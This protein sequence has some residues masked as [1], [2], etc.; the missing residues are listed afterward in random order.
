[1]LALLFLA[2]VQP[3]EPPPAFTILASADEVTLVLASNRTTPMRI[4]DPKDVEG[5]SYSLIFIRVQGPDG[6]FV[7]TRDEDGWWTPLYKSAWPVLDRAEPWEVQPGETVTRR[8]TP[9][10]LTR[11]MP[12]APTAGDCRFQVRAIIRDND[13]WPWSEDGPEGGVYTALS[14]WTA[15]PCAALFP[16]P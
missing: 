3:A 2:P 6:D 12:D 11:G 15:A 4:A 8:T 7:S 5:L 14:P 9:A 1:M 10:R 16:P 13:R